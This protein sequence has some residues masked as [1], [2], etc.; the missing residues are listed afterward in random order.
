MSRS[1]KIIRFTFWTNNLVWLTFFIGLVLLILWGQMYQNHLMLLGAALLVLG[2]LL[3]WW[4]QSYLKKHLG[5]KSFKDKYFFI[6]DEREKEIHLRILSK[7]SGL[8][9]L[10]LYVIVIMTVGLSLMPKMTVKILGIVVLTMVM[11]T[12][13]YVNYQYYYLWKKYDQ[14]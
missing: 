8:V 2:S 12:G 9:S 7:I 6:D 5:I 1:A 3:G 10:C 14:G 13:I 4:Q 11:L